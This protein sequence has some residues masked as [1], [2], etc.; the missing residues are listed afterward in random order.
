MYDII[1]QQLLIPVVTMDRA[2][3]I[4]RLTEIYLEQGFR[5][6]EVTLRTE[7]GLEALERLASKFPQ[8]LPIAGT[9]INPS[10]LDSAAKAGARLAVSPG[11]NP[12][13]LAMAK[14][15]EIPLIP[16]I[17]NPGQAEQA[18]DLGCTR[19]KLFPAEVLGGVAMV[20]ALS[21]VYSQLSFMPTGGISPENLASYLAQPSVFACGASWIA[22]RQSISQGQWE[23]VKAK[24][25]LARTLVNSIT[26]VEDPQ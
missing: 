10:L 14:S 16:G 7:A 18:M 26:T 3:D 9:V 2:V 15:L 25:V 8:A 24:V 21:A 11:F 17:A 6:I 5:A 23:E 13:T 1:D 22:P 12:K 4:D 20:K 19:V